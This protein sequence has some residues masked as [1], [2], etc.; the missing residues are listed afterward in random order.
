MSKKSMKNVLKK[1]YTLTRKETLNKTKYIEITKDSNKTPKKVIYYMHGGAYIL[2]LTNTYHSFSYPLCDIRD[3]IKVVLLDYSVAPEHKYPTQINEAMDL[4][5]ELTK[6]YSPNDIVV[7]GDSSGGNLSIAL[8]HKIKKERGTA[9]RG[10]FFLSPWTDMT[11]SGKSYYDNYSKDV[12]FG[13]P[14]KTLTEE[15]TKIIFNSEIFCFTGDAEK[16]DPYVSP[17]FGDF[18]TFPKSLFIV[19]SDEVLLDDTLNIVNKIKENKEN[20]VELLNKEGMF[21]T[22]PL[23][24]IMP[25]AREACKKIREF[26]ANCF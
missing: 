1:G 22:Y 17:L 20:E 23:M 9:P 26:I 2:G 6:E 12:Q 5:D 3:D 8:I 15:K 7:G 4:W 10:G 18:T 19:G 24:S 11:C 21:H 25:E 13:E 16:T 14:N